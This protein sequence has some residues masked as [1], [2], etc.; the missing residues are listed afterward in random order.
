MQWIDTVLIVFLLVVAVIMTFFIL[1]Q[2][3]KGGGLAALVGTKAAG[4][5]GVTNPIRRATAYLAA[6]FF[7][8]AIILGI[9][10]RPGSTQFEGEAPKAK[11]TKK[12][13][14]E[15][16]PAPKLELPVAA[17]KPAEE[18]KTG[19]EQKAADLTT[20]VAKPVEKPA[21]ATK[22]GEAAKSPEDKKPAAETAKQLDAAP[23]NLSAKATGEKPV[24]KK[25]DVE[26]K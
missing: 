9:L 1:L 15:K 18:K 17:P 5:E 16:P 12:A 25:S 19:T 22:S 13:E 10:N 3:G 11:E 4:V 8:L 24:E 21:D 20:D 23:E 26:N 6:M 14:L 2:E 7:F